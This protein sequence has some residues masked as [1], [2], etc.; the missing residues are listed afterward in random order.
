[1]Q[2]PLR[3]TWQAK[4]RYSVSLASSLPTAVQSPWRALLLMFIFISGSHLVYA[5]ETPLLV[6]EVKCLCRVGS[7]SYWVLAVHSCGVYFCQLHYQTRKWDL[8]RSTDFSRRLWSSRMQWSL[9]YL[10]LSIQAEGTAVWLYEMILEHT[11]RKQ[12]YTFSPVSINKALR[13]RNVDQSHN[14]KNSSTIS[15]GVISD[16]KTTLIS[17]IKKFCLR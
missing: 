9:P 7:S 4:R 14:F 2:T 11:R 3:K 17:S 12:F 10:E 5:S 8:K 6:K 1:M 13:R 15:L 16:C